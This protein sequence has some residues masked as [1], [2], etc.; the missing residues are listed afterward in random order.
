MGAAVEVFE[1]ALALEVDRSRFLPVKSTNDLLG[2]RSDV[3]TFTSSAELAYAD[4]VTAP[5]LV[6]LDGDYY[7]LMRDFDQRFPQGPPSLREATSLT[8][9]GDWTFGRDVVVRGD[10]RIDADGAPG[11]IESTTLEG[12]REG[13]RDG[14]DEGDS[15]GES[16]G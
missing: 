7:K 5:P 10:V 9:A 15:G 13:V 4:G 11:T 3:Y 6:D 12:G 1:G 16:D 14:D 8:V 2:L